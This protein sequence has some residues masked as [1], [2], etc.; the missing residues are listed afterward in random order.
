MIGGDFLL[1]Y[2]VLFL[3]HALCII[4]VGTIVIQSVYK[5]NAKYVL[6]QDVPME[7]K[8]VNFFNQVIY[9]LVIALI[10]IWIMYD[11]D[12]GSNEYI[13]SVIISLTGLELLF[14]TIYGAY[15]HV[16]GKDKDLSR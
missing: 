13:N 14:L 9:F 16:F 12:F 15:F 8:W 1:G 6:K 3:G 4:P 11:T 10:S 5:Y 7:I 2:I